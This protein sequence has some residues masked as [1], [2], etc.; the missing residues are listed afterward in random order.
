MKQKKLHKIN[1]KGNTPMILAVTPGGRPGQWI[2]WKDA[3][4]HYATD[5]VLWSLG[6]TV[7]TLTGGANNNNDISLIELAL[8]ISVAGMG[9]HVI[10]DRPILLTN[11]SLFKRDQNMCMY[12]GN[13]FAN[14]LLSRDH[15]IPK[16]RG[17]L[18]IW[19]NVV[20]SCLPCNSKKD[21]RTPV[22][23]NMP[24]LALPYTPNYIESFILT[25][26]NIVADQM[27]FL[28]LQLPKKA[29]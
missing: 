13:T 16:G 9:A 26:R 20:S 3:A 28:K 1:A 7:M 2:H 10:E 22:Q 19:S 24:L 18:D 8:I 6:D 17:G 15:V 5:D 29:V 11:Q 21:C 14:K 25:N 12:C 4:V 23:A 27:A